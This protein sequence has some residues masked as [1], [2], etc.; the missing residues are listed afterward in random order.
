[1][2]CEPRTDRACR[3]DSA[4]PTGAAPRIE[5]RTGRAVAPAARRRHPKPTLAREF[6]VS[7]VTIYQFLRAGPGAERPV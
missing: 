3:P 7:R 1:M 4:A 6:G 5:R 2:L